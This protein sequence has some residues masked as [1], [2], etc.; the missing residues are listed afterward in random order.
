MIYDK[1]KYI[2]LFLI[3]RNASLFRELAVGS[4]LLLSF[5]YLYT[6]QNNWSLS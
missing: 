6:K 3:L 2:F 4:F 1:Y 5:Q